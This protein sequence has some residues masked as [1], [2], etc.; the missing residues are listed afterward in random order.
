MEFGRKAGGLL[1]SFGSRNVRI[2]TD[3]W[4]LRDSMLFME[5]PLVSIGG[6]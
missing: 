5:M 3:S 2:D 6:V 1:A 4:L